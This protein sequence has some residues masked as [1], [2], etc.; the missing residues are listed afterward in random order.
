[1]F[2]VYGSIVRIDLF[3]DDSVCE[4]RF[5]ATIPKYIQHK[6]YTGYEPKISCITV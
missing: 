1:M 6:S 3:S 2:M 5:G 4:N